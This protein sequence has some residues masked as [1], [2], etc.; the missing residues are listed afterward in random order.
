MRVLLIGS[1]GREHALAFKLAQSPILTALFASP[2]SDAIADHARCAPLDLMDH[3]GIGAFCRTEAI[4]LVIVGPEAPL[5]QG[6]ADRLMAANIPVFGPAKAAAALEGSKA[7]TK[8]I[9]EAAGI[10]T[11]AGERFTEATAA[12]A[13]IEKHG[14]PLVVKADGLAAGKGVII[15]HTV[16]DARKAVDSLQQDYGDELVIEE[17]LDG[18]EMSVFGITDGETVYPFGTAE[19][20]KQ[21]YDGDKGPNTGGMGAFSPATL[22]PN[23]ETQALVDQ[24]ITP[25]VRELA[26]RGTPY[27]GIVYA[28]LMVTKDGPKL[29]EYNVRLGDPECQVLM[30]RLESDLL[31]LME[32][33]A[34]GKL[35]GQKDPAWSSNTAITV[36]MASEGYP[37]T[38]E[39]N[40]VIRGLDQ[41]NG[42]YLKVF[43]AGTQKKG[44]VYL[45]IGG[46]VLNI[47]V[48][49]TSTAAARTAAYDA[50]KKIDWP[51]SF[52]RRDIGNRR[53][54]T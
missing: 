10:P 23:T 35:D 47:S 13:F 53:Q 52:Y 45:A 18:Q 7:F 34:K 38:Y 46:R 26:A 24:F 6:L 27:C 21:A 30:L 39:K 19:D 42:P 8:E 36:V 44:D 29:L 1:G 16:E 3:D 25:A 31:P 5:V 40:T 51:E 41:L 2:G 11:A 15:A 48:V 43:H 50:I 37:G 12:Y 22:L 17:F 32:A 14:A 9:C 49:A 54:S 20:H 33:A 28:G 4:D